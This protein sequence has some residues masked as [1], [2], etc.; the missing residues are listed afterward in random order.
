[1]FADVEHH[2]DKEKE[3]HDGAGVDDEL[4]GGQKRR[5]NDIEDNSYGQQGND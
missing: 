1:M 5:T 3:H 4:E 2:Y